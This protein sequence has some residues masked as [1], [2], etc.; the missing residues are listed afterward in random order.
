MAKCR[1]CGGKA[2]VYLP[3]TNSWFCRKHFIEYFERKVW[4]TFTKYVPRKHRKILLAVSGGKDSVSLLYS[5]APRL[6][7]NG[8]EAT[9]LYIDLGIK[10]YSEY[11]REIVV[12]HTDKLGIDH[13][14]YSLDREHGFTIDMVAEK[15]LKKILKKP[16]CSICGIVKRYLYNYIAYRHGY[17]LIV[18]GHTLNDV[19]AYMLS[20]LGNGDIE[21]LVKLKP[22]IPERNSLVARAKPLMF[23]YEYENTLYVEARGIEYLKQTCPYK[24]VGKK[25]PLIDS[26]KKQLI[27]LEKKHPGIGLMF[28]RN[29]VDKIFPNII[30]DR[31][32]RL[33]KCSLCGMPSKTDPCSFCRLK[34]YMLKH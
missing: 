15:V 5:L 34:Q 14:I 3:W 7:D 11:G 12:K 27:E 9:I 24:L 30:Y 29:M 28:L 26:Y 1:V 6:I 21:D 19:Y 16:I 13:I 8:Y 17:D 31:E 4:R 20:D 32:D 33:K 10:G 22:Y 25:H 18:T 2:W 23:N